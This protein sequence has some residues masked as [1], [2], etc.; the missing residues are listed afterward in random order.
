M[1]FGIVVDF[2]VIAILFAGIWMFRSPDRAKFGN[3]SAALA[4]LFSIALVVYR[5]GI[6][7]PAI[8][9]AALLI[10]SA[11]G[12]AV[13]MRVSMI[14]IPAMVAF[15]HGA[16][17]IAAFMIS[18]I[19][20]TKASAHL[21]EVAEVSG[22]LGLIIGAATF[23]GSMIAASKLSN[24]M[25]STPTI[26]PGHNLILLIMLFLI[27]A[28]SVMGAG[29]PDINNA[30]ILL[31]L[32]SIVF[33]VVFAIRIGGADMPILISFLNATAG[34]AASLC[35]IIIANRLLIVCGATVVASG[36]MLTAI[37]C[38]AMNRS[39]L[40]IFIGIGG[41]KPASS[42]PAAQPGVAG[43]PIAKRTSDDPYGD[44]V[45]ALRDAKSVIIIPGYGMA[46]AQAQFKVVELA[47][48]LEAA[49]K[50]VVFAI[51]PVAGRMPGHMNVLL[52]EA[53]VPY[54][55]LKEMDDI[56]D[57]F[58]TT[59]VGIVIG[60]CDVVNPA[61]MTAENTPIYGMKILRVDEAKNTI[62]FNYD[63]KPGYS[64][65]PNPLYEK[66]NCI[67]LFGDAAET[68]DRVVTAL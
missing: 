16:G 59:D 43:E 29:S 44:A 13:A 32:L 66:S 25:K 26:L 23:S 64:G 17:G 45:R 55:K 53:E 8:P 65:V 67:F 3:L 50:S 40:N 60:A 49:G 7:S 68:L 2:L 30:M 12:W 5:H 1:D 54:D 56:N 6:I 35:G 27:A 14:N 39:L 9:V 47:N 31:I 46:I 18:Y 63:T 24:K 4:I 22:I 57:E 20:I 34:L 21:G 36:S 62:V 37:M 61:A 48:K 19:E 28:I 15:Q 10:G 11:S 52:A 38:K 51:H 42:I 41:V 33:G 58:K